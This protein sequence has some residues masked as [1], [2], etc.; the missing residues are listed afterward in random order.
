MECRVHPQGVLGNLMLLHQGGGLPVCLQGV[1]ALCFLLE[2]EKLQYPSICYD[3]LVI[4]GCPSVLLD[5]DGP[6]VCSS[7]AAS[8][9]EPPIRTDLLSEVRQ[10]HTF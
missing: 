5:E 3:A 2:P 10:V 4:S 1:K 7:D 9:L 6:A 8:G